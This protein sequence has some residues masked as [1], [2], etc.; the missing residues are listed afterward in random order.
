MRRLET[1]MGIDLVVFIRDRYEVQ[2][3]TQQEIADEL[4]VDVATVSR[5]MTKL[6]IETRLFASERAVAS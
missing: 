4:K 1:R 2:G 6:G 3:R 5:W